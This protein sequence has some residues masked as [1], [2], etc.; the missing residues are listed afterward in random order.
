MV[1]TTTVATNIQ[2]DPAIEAVPSAIRLKAFI[3]PAAYRRS[4]TWNMVRRTLYI[5]VTGGAFCVLQADHAEDP[6][7][8]ALPDDRGSCAPGG[9]IR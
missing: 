4:V 6:A 9:V 5:L 2:G 1:V 8:S 7:Y 3:I